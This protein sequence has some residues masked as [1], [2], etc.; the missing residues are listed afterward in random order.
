MSRQDELEEALVRELG[1]RIGFGRAMELCER[2]WREK[3][4]NDGMFLG[5]KLTVGPCAGLLVPCVCLKL[6]EQVGACDW[7]CGTRRVTE[8]VKEVIRERNK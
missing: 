5:G 2:L 6:G 1:L 8:K 4:A 7:C 3:L